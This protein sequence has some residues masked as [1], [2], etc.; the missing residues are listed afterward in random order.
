MWPSL[1][2]NQGLADYEMKTYKFHIVSF[3]FKVIVFPL[4][5]WFLFYFW[6]HQ[7]TRF[8]TICCRHVELKIKNNE[9]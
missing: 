7:N 4:V 5:T 8:T 1:G 3:R 9:H 6:L 2:S